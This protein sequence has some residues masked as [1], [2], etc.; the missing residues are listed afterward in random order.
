MTLLKKS[1]HHPAGFEEV[2]A[3]YKGFDSD[4]EGFYVEMEG[5]EHFIQLNGEYSCLRKDNRN[6][7]YIY[8]KES[9]KKAAE[10][11]TLDQIL[12]T[13]VKIIKNNE[14]LTG[15]LFYQNNEK[16]Y[17]LP[18]QNPIVESIPIKD[19]KYIEQGPKKINLQSFYKN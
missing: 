1:D 10:N 2:S 5:Q 7:S 18:T 13:E 6:K 16:I 8:N 9:I 3:K 4:N 11:T 19:I 15:R 14:E 12:N 17:F